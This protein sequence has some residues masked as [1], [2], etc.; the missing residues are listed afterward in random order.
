ML[1][2]SGFSAKPLIFL[3]LYAA[4]LLPGLVLAAKKAPLPIPLELEKSAAPT[5]WTRYSGWPDTDWKEYNTLGKLASPAYAPP[6]KLEGPLTGDPKN[7]EKLAF[8]R[9]RGGSCVACHI[10]GPATPSMPGNV[11]PDLSTIATWGRGDEWLFNYVYD[12]RSVNPV[13]VMPPWGAHKLFTVD[14]IKDIMVFLKTLKEPAKF[15]DALENPQT[16]PIPTETRDNLDP[17]VNNATQ[18]LDEAQTLYAQSGPSGKSCASCHAKP[19]QAFKTWAAKMPRYEPRL[20]RVLGVE[21]FVTR[22]A[23]AATGHDYP[24]QSAENIALSIYLRNL[25]NGMPIAVDIRLPGA[26]EANARGLAFIDRKLGQL[27]FACSDCHDKAANK[28]VRGQYLTGQVGQV[29]HFPNWRT[30]RAEIWDLRR[31][32]QW[33]NV[34]IRANELPPDAA[35]YGDLELALTA[36]NN[37][38]KLNVPGIRH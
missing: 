11:G 19:E 13:T 31:R 14:E 10:M 27:N 1:P 35:E 22:H 24:M 5:P 15:K 7:G 36:I 37:G 12:A 33:C 34:A 8:D 9:S 3:S 16:R 18:A 4:L 32:F 20:K 21:E 38:Q 30:S 28:W 29:A 25:A 2:R 6:P 17:F 26:K 23:R